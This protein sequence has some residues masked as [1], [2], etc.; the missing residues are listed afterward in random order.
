[1]SGPLESRGEP[2]ERATGRILALDP[3]TRRTGI[4]L[5]DPSRALAA[6]LETVSL[7]PAALVEHVAELV[8]AHEVVEVVVGLPATPGGEPGESEK[9]ARGLAERLRRRLDVAVVLWNESLSSWEAERILAGRPGRARRKPAGGRE[10]G[11]SR[12]RPGGRAREDRE[13]GEVDRLAAA[14]VLQDYL[15]ARAKRERGG[16]ATPAGAGD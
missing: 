8:R 7:A 9:L 5:S 3:G 13:R 15:D 2:R 11:G 12:G 16:Q 10:R 1:M 4:A 14:L 6:P